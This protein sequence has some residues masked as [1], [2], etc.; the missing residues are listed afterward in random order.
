VALVAFAVSAAI[1][2]KVPTASSLRPASAE[3]TS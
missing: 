2:V 1:A 3:R